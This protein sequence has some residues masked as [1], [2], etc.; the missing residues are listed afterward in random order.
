MFLADVALGK[1]LVPKTSGSYS[2]TNGFD[3]VWAKPKES[4]VI[5]DEMIIYDTRQCNLVYLIEFA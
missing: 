1:Y 4:G 3:S 5:N 2:N